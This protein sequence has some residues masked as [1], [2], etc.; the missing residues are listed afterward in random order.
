MQ[1]IIGYETP[2][3]KQRGF[4]LIEL[5]VVV[6]IIALLMALLLPALAS[7]RGAADRVKCLS[8]QR[9]LGIATHTYANEHQSMMPRGNTV[10]GP[11]ES[12]GQAQSRVWFVALNPYL[13][14][15]VGQ[16]ADPELSEMRQ[17]AEFKQDPVW[18]SIA[19]EPMDPSGQN[20][21]EM[22][23]TIKMNSAFSVTNQFSAH[24]GMHSPRQRANPRMAAIRD[25]SRTVLYGD[26]IAQ[27]IDP[28]LSVRPAPF[29]FSMNWEIVGLRHSEGA[30]I[31]FVDGSARHVTQEVTHSPVGDAK[32]WYPEY[33][34]PFTRERH[35]QQELV[36]DF[37]VAR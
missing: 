6:S 32:A 2:T 35:D 13:G 21:R 16:D 25:T 36:W 11:G 12:D 5:L 3:S 7:V 4:T 15:E 28:G 10:S 37:R 31:T 8:N 18:E 9:Q 30:N 27:D 20:N 33:E 14:R 26:G 29:Q 23:R 22:N 19:K 24:S 17:Y 1:C 34:N